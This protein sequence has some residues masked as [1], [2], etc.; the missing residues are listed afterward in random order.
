[1]TAQSMCAK[2]WKVGDVVE[3]PGGFL[4]DD[5]AGLVFDLWIAQ[6]WEKNGLVYL[7]DRNTNSYA[8]FMPDE[9]F[10]VRRVG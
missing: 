4:H 6:I 8:W 2:D 1:M 10:P 9:S 3:V 7:E 5:L